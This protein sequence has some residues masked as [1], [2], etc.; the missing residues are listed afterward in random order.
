MADQTAEEAKNEY[1]QRMGEALGT[2]FAALWQEVA[3][4]HMKWA[5]YVALF[6]TK[7]SRIE[8]LNKAAPSFFRLVQD[9][10]W[11]ETLLHIARL[12]D[13][14]ESGKGKPNL[15]IRNLPKLVD[16]AATRTVLG[17]LVAVAVKQTEFCRDWRNRHIAHRDLKL[18]LDG[19]AEPLLD[20]SR[21]QV[22][23][24]LE[25]LTSMQNAVRAH[26]M[27]SESYFRLGRGAGG[28]VSLLYVLDDG[29]RADAERIERLSRGEFA[30]VD[31]A[32]DL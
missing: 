11:E 5:E 31:F 29:L 19:E 4:L 8:L 26:Y 28:A 9:T 21:R 17:E 14:S 25:T 22:N 27:K 18:A 20:A 2:Q 1:I 3:Y 10:L 15:T 23:V 16:D 12:T 7:P 24:A 6:G 32:R 13:P 30:E